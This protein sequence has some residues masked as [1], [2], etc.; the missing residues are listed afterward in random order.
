MPQTLVEKIAQKY[1]VGLAAGHE[2][3]AGDFLSVRPAHCMTHDNTDAV[4]PKFKSIGAT[5]VH[6][7]RQPVFCLDHDIQNQS[8]ENLAKYAKIEQFARTH[9]IDF[10]PVG[11]GIGHQV[12]LE[13]GYVLPGAFVV[14]S[15][16][17]SNIYG[18]LGALGTPVVRTDAAAI[19]ATGRTWWQVPDVVRVTLRG[20]LPPGAS[21]KDVIIT[22]IGTFN[23]DEVLNCC[24]EFAGPGVASL[25]IEERMTIAN[26]STEWGAL[27][28]VFPCDDVTRRYLLTR[29]GVRAAREGEAPAEPSAGPGERGKLEREDGASP[30]HLPTFPPSHNP[31]PP[32]E[33]GDSGSAGA[34]PSRLARER[35]EQVC[36]ETPRADA[37]AFYAKELD[38]DLSTVS[39]YVAGPNEVKTIAA[40]GE[41]EQRNVRI[42]KAFLMSC[43]N[44]RLA[45]MAAAADVLQGRKVAPHVKFYVAAASSEV[46]AQAKAQGYWKVLTDAGAIFLPAGCGACI[47]LGEGVLS[48]NEVGISATNRNFDGRMGSRKSQVYLASPAVVAA[49]A[50][51]GKIA[52][53][54]PSA[55][56]RQPSAVSRQPSAVSSQ[57][58]VASRQPS[59]GKAGHAIRVNERPARAKA[60]VEI[61]PGFPRSIAGELLLVP[62]DNLN[63]DGMYG[64]EYTYKTLAP[65]EMARV[66]MANYDPEF[67]NIAKQVGLV[68]GAPGTGTPAGGAGPEHGDLLVGG[69]NFGAG[70]SREQAATA[71]KHRGLQLIIAGSFSQTYSRNAYNNAFICLECPKLV[72]DLRAACANAKGPDGKPA[73]TIRTGWQA[74]VDFPA[75]VIRVQTADGLE[76]TYAFPPLGPVAQELVLKGGFEAVIRDQLK[77]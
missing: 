13:E 76:R 37:D 35:V 33:R 3:H 56:S 31:S 42:D 5:Q 23:Q 40:V 19:W 52:G 7:P 32:R 12:M 64:K 28:A 43:V 38:F 10:Y 9:G 48:D 73:R 36:R 30:S 15:D 66:A 74:T 65:E 44:G 1:A 77:R 47:G 61:L 17:H 18:A 21:G 62:K 39:P 11:R 68:A 16:S 57:P 54:R 24:L 20:Q 67:Q 58:S 4:I 59:A 2:V 46:E 70:S 29:A 26:M 63:T 55:V 53:P 45:D 8:P 41:L 49:S 22:L 75:S 14:A 25:S 72:D 50:A 71:L 60:K 6:D 51:A 34:S 27:A 69:Y